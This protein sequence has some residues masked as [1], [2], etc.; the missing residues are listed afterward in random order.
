M[1]IICQIDHLHAPA[2]TTI[3]MHA[4]IPQHNQQDGATQPAAWGR[5]GV[6]VLHVINLTTIYIIIISVSFEF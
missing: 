3:R 5:Q 6:R 4:C 2:S 1:L